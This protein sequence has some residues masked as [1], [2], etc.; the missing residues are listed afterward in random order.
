M[1]ELVR[2]L[3]AGLLGGLVA[4]TF[5]VGGGIVLVPILVLLLHRPQHVAHATSLVAVGMGALAGALRFGL[6][7]AVAIVPALLLA[8][9]SIA[10]A[11][12]GARVMADLP[13]RTLRRL[14]SALLLLVA[15]RFLLGSSGA[16][17]LGAEVPELDALSAAVHVGG[18]FVAGV[19]SSVL[20]VGGGI[21]MV[22]LLALGLGYGQHVAEGTSLA[23]IVPTAVTG[24]RRHAASGFTD[25]HLG[26]RLGVGALVGALVGASLALALDADDLARAFG[27]LQV[28][29]AALLLRRRDR[30]SAAD[31]R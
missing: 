15:V 19:V 30:R 24:A 2:V 22:P 12:V 11:R 26:V 29:M 17:G 21:I 16:D 9:G 6:D 10:G 4:G 18:G 8:A 13:E 27:V 1:S 31:A 3:F 23:V 25:W 5:G 20:G 28:L 14:F 7:G